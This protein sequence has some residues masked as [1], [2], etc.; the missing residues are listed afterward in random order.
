[1][2][3]R[4]RTML[5]WAAFIIPLAVLASGD[6]H[7]QS[8]ASYPERQITIIVPFPPGGSVDVLGRTIAQKLN[9]AWGK[10][11]VV[12]NRAGASTIIGTTALA[13][14]P[15]DGYT[16]IIAVSSHTTNPS[17]STKLPF[18]TEKDFAPIALLAKAP[19]VLYANPKFPPNNLKELVAHAKTETKLNFASA[20]VGTMTH[21]TA[22]LFK[23]NAKVD[24]T[25]ILYRGGTPAMND[26][27][28]GHLPMS[29]GTVAQALPQYKAG[30]LKALA[31]SSD[32]RYPSIPEVP[33][34]KEQGFDVVT[35]EW[36]GLLAPAG[37]PQPIIDKLNAEMA[38]IVKAPDLGERLTAIELVHS[39]PAELGSFI[40]SETDRWA[41]LIKSLKLSI[42]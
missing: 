29:F 31:V 32:Q 17:L 7:A 8:A 20:G 42:E 27:I 36:Y 16:L 33:T 5:I 22:E 23:T 14:A 21:L 25:H 40:K 18:D 37:T 30:V 38:R 3:M 11:V 2:T 19:V 12:E 35:T 24:M 13:K 1:M 9:D 26:L 41:P 34:F 28:A 6:S 39:T 4:R 10:P 15:P